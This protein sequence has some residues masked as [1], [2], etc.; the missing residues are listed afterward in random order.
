MKIHELCPNCD[1]E[2]KLKN[3]F[4]VQTCPNCNTPIKPCSICKHDKN[5]MKCNSCPLETVTNNK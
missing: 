5:Y 4:E 3:N 2:V 1:T